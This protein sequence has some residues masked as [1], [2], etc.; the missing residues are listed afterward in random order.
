VRSTVSA[1][2]YISRHGTPHRAGDVA[3]L[4]VSRAR[5]EVARPI[6]AL[7]LDRRRAGARAFALAVRS[8]RCVRLHL[9]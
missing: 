7:A 4:D 2:R 1:Y 6:D 5:T 9:G 8:A 3:E